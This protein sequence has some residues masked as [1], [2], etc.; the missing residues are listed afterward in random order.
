M[1]ESKCSVARG[2]V[3]KTLPA[4]PTCELP[5][6]LK[7]KTGPPVAYLRSSNH[8]WPNPEEGVSLEAA[9]FSKP[10]RKL[11]D[12]LMRKENQ[13]VPQSGTYPIES[14]L[15]TG[16]AANEEQISGSDLKRHS[17]FYLSSFQKRVF[18]CSS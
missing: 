11:K 4:V 3:G 8:G 5:R 16:Q 6:E 18:I 2:L 9:N 10:W 1:S 12:K 13:N 7:E 17:Y 15:Q 14:V